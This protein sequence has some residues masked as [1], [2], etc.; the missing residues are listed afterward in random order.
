[1]YGTKRSGSYECPVEERRRNLL[2]L[3]IC[4]YHLE[5]AGFHYKMV[6]R[7]IFMFL[8]SKESFF[9]INLNT[10]ESCY[11]KSPNTRFSTH[12]NYCTHFPKAGQ[13]RGL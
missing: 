10:G 2:S 12:R 7:A 3:I 5:S 4:F 1:M 6:S 8:S 9:I 13:E 11:E